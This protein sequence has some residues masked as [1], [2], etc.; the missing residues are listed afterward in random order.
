MISLNISIQFPNGPIEEDSL[1]KSLKSRGF[2]LQYL[3]A[4]QFLKETRIMYQLHHDSF[5][6]KPYFDSTLLDYDQYMKCFLEPIFHES[7]PLDSNSLSSSSSLSS[8]SPFF[9]SN[10]SIFSYSA[11]ILN[12]SKIPI[13]FFIGYKDPSPTCHRFIFRFSCSLPPTRGGDLILMYF[14][15][16]LTKLVLHHDESCQY[17]ILLVSI[18]EKLGDKIGFY[19]KEKGFLNESCLESSC[20]KHRYSM[21]RYNGTEKNEPT[22]RIH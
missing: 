17:D 3:D 15:Y 14:H 10:S 7:I 1:I 8:L 2:E 21:Y 20:W 6:R 4:T 5:L 19:L 16:I 22:K 18:T 9:A 13:G 11:F 12:A